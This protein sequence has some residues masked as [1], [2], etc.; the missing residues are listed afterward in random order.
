MSAGAEL[1]HVDEHSLVIAADRGTT[2]EAL[3]RVVDA[4]FSAGAVPPVARLLGCADTAVSGPR[5]LEAGS[6]VPGFQVATADTP[7][8]LALVGRHRFSGYALIFRLD[9]LDR[10]RTRVQAETRADFPGLKGEVYKTLVIRT[11]MHVLVTRRILG[12]AKR[13]AER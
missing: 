11:R 3:S 2:W 10:G 5:P 6:T 4:S 12:A 1:P 7:A 13:R 8:E 9:E